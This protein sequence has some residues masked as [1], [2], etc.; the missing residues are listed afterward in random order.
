M[1]D[2]IADM[3]ILFEK[4]EA[5]GE[6]FS[7]RWVIAMLLSSLPPSF[8]TLVTALE[9]T[10]E[11]QRQAKDATPNSVLNSSKIPQ[12]KQDDYSGK[13][14]HYCKIKGHLKKNCWKFKKDNQRTTNESK[15]QANNVE[16]KD[17]YIFSCAGD[18]SCWM[19]DSGATCH[20]STRREDFITL[21]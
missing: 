8:D 6:R 3:K 16:S 1:S 7:E 21:N 5:V 10:E 9:L 4:L 17:N 11:Y 18:V 12:V 20:I 13:R 19:L 15:Q 2:Y 14:C